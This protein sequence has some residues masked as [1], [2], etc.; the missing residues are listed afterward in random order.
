M[1]ADRSVLDILAMMATISPPIM[2]NV[3]TG[4]GTDLARATYRYQTS[5]RH[6]GGEGGGG[7]NTNIN[8]VVVL[9]V[10]HGQSIER[11]A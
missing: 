5:Q 10:N 7:S 2:I 1:P 6:A 8:A 11:L 3:V 9:D 4:E